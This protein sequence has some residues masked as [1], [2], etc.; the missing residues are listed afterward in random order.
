MPSKQYDRLLAAFRAYVDNDL[1][2]ADPEYVREVLTD[3]CGLGAEE[4]KEFGFDWLWP[5]EEDL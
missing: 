1:A 3:V 2:C 5:E 4:L